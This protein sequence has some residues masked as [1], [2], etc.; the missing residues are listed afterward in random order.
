MGSEWGLIPKEFAVKIYDIL[1]KHC[2][3][4]DTDL[5]KEAFIYNATEGNGIIEYRICYALGGGGKFWNNNDWYVNCYPEDSDERKEKIIEA[6][7]HELS[8]LRA[9]YLKAGK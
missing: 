1:V 3:A 4:P 8:L 2:G 7:N 5:E 6:T 9:E